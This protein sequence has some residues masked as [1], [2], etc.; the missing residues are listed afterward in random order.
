MKKANSMKIGDA[1]LQIYRPVRTMMVELPYFKGQIIIFN[2]MAGHV[3]G[4]FKFINPCEKGKP[5]VIRGSKATVQII[6]KSGC[7]GYR[8]YLYYE[9][10]KL[11]ILYLVYFNTIFF[12]H[13]FEK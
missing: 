10:K 9:N 3:I 8:R 1:K 7:S 5:G 4:F 11:F 13:R 12:F 6:K 2:P